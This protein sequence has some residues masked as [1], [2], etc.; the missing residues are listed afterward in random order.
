MYD[1]KPLSAEQ[2]TNAIQ[3]Q[4]GGSEFFHH[5]RAFTLIRTEHDR[6]YREVAFPSAEARAAIEGFSHPNKLLLGDGVTRDKAQ[7]QRARD[8]ASFVK[9]SR[10]GAPQS[11]YLSRLAAFFDDAVLAF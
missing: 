6:I 2:Q 10:H 5:L 9:A 4:I 7:R 1:L 8:G 11:E 3:A